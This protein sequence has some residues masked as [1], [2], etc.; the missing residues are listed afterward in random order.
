MIIKNSVARWFDGRTRLV[1]GDDDRP[2]LVPFT[3]ARAQPF[4]AV[5]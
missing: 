5:A 3:E 4:N 2:G 1:F